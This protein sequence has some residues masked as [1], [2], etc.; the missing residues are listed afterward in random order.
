MVAQPSNRRPVVRLLLTLAFTLAVVVGFGGGVLGVLEGADRTGQ[1]LG[2]LHLGW[3]VGS[4]AIWSVTVLIQA[5]RW[6][7]LMPVVRRPPVLALA[8]VVLGSNA[9]TLAL[10]GP[11]GEFAGAWYV[12]HRYGVPMAVALA[13]ALLGR[14]L[15]ILCFG[16][17]TLALWPLRAASLPAD[18]VRLITPIAAVTGAITLPIAGLC[19]RP[20]ALMAIASRFTLQLLPGPAGSRIRERLAWWSLCFGALGRIGARRWAAA[21]GACFVNLTVMTVSTLASFRA[22]GLAADPVGTAFMQAATAVASVAGVLVPGGF[23]AVEVLVVALFPTFAS[24]GTA[25][26]V[27]VAVVLRL[28]HVATLFLGVPAMVWLSA[29]LPDEAEV[30][31]PLANVTGPSASA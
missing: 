24:G 18:V 10:P 2:Q 16:V 3:L 14:A 26:A 17:A 29:S 4:V 19:F 8:W 9:L 21:T 12:R 13:S 30:L 11:V 25:D 6:R 5:V 22:I 7:A 27:F 31:A 1:R 15:A 23:G 28:V 20:E